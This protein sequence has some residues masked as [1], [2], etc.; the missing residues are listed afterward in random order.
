MLITPIELDFLNK[1]ITQLKIRTSFSTEDV[2]CRLYYT[3]LTS[4]NEILSTGVID[5]TS[6]EYD[7]WGQSNSYIDDLVLT[8]LGLSRLA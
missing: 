8:R 4:T 7:A 6:Q 2:T 5:L 1:T 3:L